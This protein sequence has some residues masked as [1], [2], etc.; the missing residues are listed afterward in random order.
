[1]ALWS[2]SK[3]LFS[4]LSQMPHDA[5]RQERKEMVLHCAQQVGTPI[6]FAITIIMAAF[7]P[8]FTFEGVA[9]KLFRPLVFTMNFYLIGAIVAALFIIPSLIGIFLT[10]K[11]LSHRESPVIKVAHFFYKPV[12]GWSLRHAKLVMLGAFISLGLAAFIG[13]H[14][15]S[16]FL[17]A[18][19]EGN[20]WLR[21]TVLPTSVSL[22]ESVKT[23][24]KLRRILEKFPE[25]KNVTSQTG[26]PDDGTDPNLFSNI[27]VFLDIKPADQWRPEF[28]GNKAELVKALNKAVSVVP[29]ALFY[30]SQYIQD[31]VDEA[32]AGAK[33]TLAIKNLWTGY[34]RA[35]RSGR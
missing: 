17:P 30:F 19:D 10:R 1:M 15:G 6:L 32:V 21:V 11:A 5:T 33:G 34:H 12:L 3:M 27:E 20:I 16:E 29:N 18:L 22:E 23:A 25:I 35:A 24:G 8:I 9:G 4:Q 7:L 28:H 2:W 31:N 14:V 26:C 13:S